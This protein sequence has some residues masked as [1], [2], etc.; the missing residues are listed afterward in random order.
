MLL[1]EQLGRMRG[2]VHEAMEEGALGVGASLIYS[3]ANYAETPELAALATAKKD[4]LATLH[5]QVTQAEAE[6]GAA[7][8]NLRKAE[9]SL[10]KLARTQM[11]A[12]EAGEAVEPE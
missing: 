7:E 6:A 2:V 1:P 11:P 10:L 5:A 4:A 9:E 12:P 3:P 8:A